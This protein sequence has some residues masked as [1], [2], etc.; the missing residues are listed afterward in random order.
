[1]AFFFLLIFV[2]IASLSLCAITINRL[3]AYINRY[4]FDE[5]VYTLL[6]GFVRLRYFVW[7]Y[8]FLTLFGAVVGVFLAT[9]FL[10][11]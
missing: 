10:P 11:S 1:M 7:F 3:Y 9:L 2:Q 6:F 8:V 4:S 5:S